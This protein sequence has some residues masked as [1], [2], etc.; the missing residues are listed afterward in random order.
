T[1]DAGTGNSFSIEGFIFIQT[2]ANFSNFQIAQLTTGTGND[3]L[4]AT[5]LPLYQLN[6]VDPG[7]ADT[8]DF[9]LD[10]AAVAQSGARVDIV[11]NGGTPDRIDLDV[12]STGDPTNF[13]IY[14]HPQAVLLNNLNLTFNT[15]VEELH[16]TDHA[17]DT[18]VTT[19]PGSGFDTLLIKS[20]VT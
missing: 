9:T 20:G 17:A 3:H 18:T 15:G 6:I 16:I 13:D 8:Y 12:D 19:A 10:Q 7:G 2:Q 1:A 14:L 4:S 5:A 11:D